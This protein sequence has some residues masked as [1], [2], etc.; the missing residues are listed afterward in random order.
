MAATT[1]TA[2][3]AAQNGD[4]TTAPIGE[5]VRRLAIPASVGFFFNTMYNVVD[6][7]YAGRF[8]TDALAALSLSFPVFFVLIAMGSG[9]STGAT[10]LIGQALG[11]GDRREAALIGVQGVV[12]GWLVTGVIMVTGYLA[13]P[14]LFRLLGASDE[15]LAICLEYIRVILAGTPVV[16]TFYMFNGI[17]QAQGDTRSFRDYLIVA[18][19]VNIGLDPWFMYGGLGVPAMGV[20]GIALATVIAQSGGVVFLG[21][22]ARRTG[23]LFRSEGAQWRPHWTTLRAIAGQGIPASL[24]M[25]SVALG[26]FIITYFLSKFGQDTVAA[27]GAATRI[28]QI[29]LLPAIGLN[30]AALTLAAQN[31]GAGR[32]DRVRSAIRTAL[33]YGAIVM[34][35]GTAL[36]YFGARPLMSLFTD[37][38]AVIDIGAPYLRIAAFVQFAYVALFINTSAL[39]GL[40]MPGFALWI[41]LFRQILAPAAIFYLMTEVWDVGLF[42]IWWGIFAITWAAAF[43]AIVF[44]QRRVKMLEERQAAVEAETA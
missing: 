31:G 7:F 39:Q 36:I 23:L 30:V 33:T 12:M 13:S 26:I 24:N 8:S 27:Y 3:A 37:D 42:G 18:T 10:A 34:V 6:T 38:V 41:G 40:K 4:L 32:F 44:A 11:A 17:L 35:F 22:R 14:S 15:Y 25:M 1:A 5:L 16:L 9:F 21:W 29:V 2:R 28:E 19:I 43:I 20:G